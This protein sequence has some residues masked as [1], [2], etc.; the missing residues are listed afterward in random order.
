MFSDSSFHN[1]D[2]GL[3]PAGMTIMRFL[4]WAHVHALFWR[5]VQ[6]SLSCVRT[7][8]IS[9]SS[10]ALHV[11]A[12]FFRA[13][14]PQDSV[15]PEV[16][17]VPCQRMMKASLLYP[18]S[19]SLLAKLHWLFSNLTAHSGCEEKKSTYNTNQLILKY[20][21][22]STLSMLTLYL[23]FNGGGQDV[24]PVKPLTSLWLHT[25]MAVNLLGGWRQLCHV[26]S[27]RS[28]KR[29]LSERSCRF[30]RN[31]TILWHHIT[32]VSPWGTGIIPEHFGKLEELHAVYRVH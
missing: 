16:D 5:W 22:S 4:Q 8:Q 11:D 28:G 20:I 24:G 14:R 1:W 7:P 13:L 29:K 18:F 19:C 2:T 31:Q 26:I 32:V 6:R 10:L 12:D 30:L 27:R 17:A 3:G 25:V 21:F 15:N 9:Q 23:A